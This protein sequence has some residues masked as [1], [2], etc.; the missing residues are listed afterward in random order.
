MIFIRK[1]YY[2]LPEP[3]VYCLSKGKAHQPCEFGAKAGIVRGK[4]SPRRRRL[5]LKMAF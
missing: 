3:Q 5:P 1:W 4:M 2:P